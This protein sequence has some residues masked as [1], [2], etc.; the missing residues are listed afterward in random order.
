MKFS[1]RIFLF[2]L[3]IV[4][5]GPAAAQD[6]ALKT[7]LVGWATTN[8]NLGAEFALDNKNTLQAFALVNPWEFGEDKHFRF[9]IVEPEYR[10]WFCSKFN[11][12]FI[13]AHL[14]G[15]QYN[16]KNLNF[17][18]KMF[19]VGSSV[20][21]SD[22]TSMTGDGWPDLTGVNSGRHAEGWYIG[23][24]VTGGYQW[25]LSRHWNLE[26]SLGIGYAYSPMTFCGRC[27]RTVDKRR[28]HYFGPTKLAVSLMYVF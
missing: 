3:S 5:L 7:N 28:L 1:R 24:G 16:A 26:A 13:G 9:W 25:I 22:G 4:S 18:L 8:I 6:A 20:Y 15:G 12:W 2:L 21:D 27:D 19:I 14:L 11:G 23:G 17:P 10:Y